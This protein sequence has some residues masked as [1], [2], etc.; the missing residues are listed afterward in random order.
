[1]Y[2]ITK[3]KELAKEHW[4]VLPTVIIIFGFVVCFTATSFGR[5]HPASEF[6]F[7]IAW[8]GMII[9]MLG[10]TGTVLGLFHIRFMKG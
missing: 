8:F 3:V 2:I 10:S 1:M 5:I 4:I 7:T 9:I 6:W